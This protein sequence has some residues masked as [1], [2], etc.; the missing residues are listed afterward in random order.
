MEFEL[1]GGMNLADATDSLKPGS[2]AFLQ[3]TRRYL[4]GRIVSRLPMGGEIYTLPSGDIPISI[5]RLNDATPGGPVAGY[6]LVIG[7]A[8]G[9]VYVNASLVLSGLSGNPLSAVIFRPNASP[10]PL[11]YLG[12]ANG[13]NKI[14]SDGTAWHT[15]VKE[16]QT[17]PYIGLGGTTLTGTFTLNGNSAPWTNYGSVNSIANYGETSYGSGGADNGPGVIGNMVAGATLTLTVTGTA[18]INGSSHAPGDS[19]PSTSTYPGDYVVGGSPEIVLGA[20][21]DASGNIVPT[22]VGGVTPAVYKVGASNVLTVPPAAV[23]FQIGVDSS[24][25]TF[26]LNSGSFAV[27][28]SLAI[29]AASPNT[30]IAGSVI[31]YV[32]GTPPPAGGGSPHF[33][34]VAEYIWRSPSDGGSGTTRSTSDPVPNSSPTNNSLIFDSTPSSGSSPVVWSTL[35]GSTVTGSISLY[36]PA[37]ESEGYQDFNCC[38]VASLFVPAQGTYTIQFVNKDQIMV[39]IGGGATGPTA[40]GP[41][42]QSISVVSGLP[43]MYVSVPNGEGGAVTSSISVTFPGQGI[44]PIEIDWDYWYHS[45]RTLVVTMSPTPGAGVAT[46]PPLQGSLYH[47]DASYRG[48]Y[49]SS[50]T[51]AASNPSPASNPQ[52]IPLQANLITIPYSTDPQV[53]LCDYYRL[54]E[55]LASYTYVATG[56][57]DGLGPLVNGVQYNTPILD[58]LTDLA[59]ETNPQL[60]YDNFEPFPSIDMPAKGVINVGNGGNITWVSGTKFNTRWLPGTVIL[61]GTPSAVAYTLYNRPTSTTTMLI[62]GVDSGNNLAYSIEEPILAAQ[63]SPAI[64]GPTPDNAGAF[65]FGLDPL[66]TGDLVWS[67]G[68]SFDAAPDTNRLNVTSP[69]EPL[70]NGT[71]TAELSTVFSTE[72]FWLIYPNFSDAIAAATGVQGVQWTLTQSASTRGLYARYAIAA[73]GALTAFRARDGIFVSAAGGPEKC[74]TDAIRNLFPQEGSTPSVVTIGGQSVYPPNDALLN[75]QTITMVPGYIY[76]DYVDITS[77][78]RTLVFDWESKGW[79]VDSYTPVAQCHAWQEGI[80]ADGVL[81]GCLDSTIRQMQTGGTEV[82]TCIVATPSVNGGSQRTIKRVG[83][84][85]V[86]ATAPAAITHTFYSNRYQTAITGTSPTTLGINAVETD[87]LIDFTAATNAD[88]QDLGLELSFPLGSSD[89]LKEWQIDWT[90]MP[91]PIVAWRTG[92]LAY[93]MNGWLHIGWIRFAYQSTTTVN[94]TL[95]TDQAQSV[96]LAIPASGGVPA[97]YFTWV[98]PLGVAGG[99][100]KFKMAEWTADAG[101]TPFTLFAGDIEVAIKQWGTTAEYREL[102]P[103]SGQG[104]GVRE[105]TT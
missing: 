8:A 105:S 24:A 63:P 14:R 3:N 22:T 40:S 32:W 104:M 74:I 69:A 30:A 9:K 87:Y 93:G 31:A 2:Y 48:A 12:D 67:K 52:T 15:G 25:N 29:A 73:Q 65:Y 47:I 101:G 11:C 77:T 34:P 70:M 98:P 21:T 58:T 49:R 95:T 26:Y 59:V 28:W 54:D 71:V 99:S 19:G 62:P 27:A 56:P 55:G 102:R 51:G 92:M 53:D 60:Q 61:I 89:I 79:G 90:E 45:G 97:K 75:S 103:F 41:F 35:T 6:V 68:N 5:E 82:G 36:A 94:L 91:Q 23:Q 66:N 96:T 88:V 4:N 85:F 38:I 81:V 57:N 39:G 64:W 84:V 13:N 78:H 100:M 10:Q 7:G 44:Y 43:L 37:L 17:A 42:G 86:R 33:G 80:S 16:P 72:R 20:F 76:F 83:G 18:T 50:Q 46:I 1:K